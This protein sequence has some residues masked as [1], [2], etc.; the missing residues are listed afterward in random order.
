[1]LVDAEPSGPEELDDGRFRRNRVLVI[2]GGHRVDLDAFLGMVEAICGPRGWAWAHVTQPA[3]QRWLRPEHAGQWDSVLCHDLPGLDLKR[4]SPPRPNG[5]SADVADALRALLERGQGVVALHHALA[6]WPGWEG[7]AE[8]L[9]GRFLYAPGH[10]RG[11]EWP[12]SGYRM[13]EHTI[14]VVAPDHPICAGVEPS[15]TI[16][17]ELYFAPVLE[18]R[19]TPLLRSRADFDGAG[20]L[21]TYDVVCH[22]ASTGKTCAGQPMAS[23]LVGW[24]TTAGRSPIAVLQPG[25]GPATFAHPAFRRLLANA[26]AWVASPAAHAVAAAGPV[27]IPPVAE[28]V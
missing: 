9:G 16:D 4:G 13:A 23:D 15:F 7:W 22:G 18:D 11:R 2:T 20:F 5:P 12:A 19:I 1:V 17:D 10:L 6:G 21:D 24:T 28:P 8:A 14:D 27:A 25:D 3:A 26:L